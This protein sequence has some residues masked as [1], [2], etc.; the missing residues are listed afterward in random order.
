MPARA[1]QRSSIFVILNLGL[2]LSDAKSDTNSTTTS[3]NLPL[4]MESHRPLPSRRP[5]HVEVSVRPSLANALPQ[6]EE[7]W[8]EVLEATPQ[9]VLLGKHGELDLTKA[10]SDL[11]AATIQ[12]IVVDDNSDD[13]GGN[14]KGIFRRTESFL[15]HAFVL[16]DE[17]A[18]TEE[19]QPAAGGDDEWTAGCDNL[20][21]PH[22]SLH[23]SWE[24]LIFE[25]HIKRQLLDYAQSA[26]LFSDKRVSSHIVQWNRMILFHGKCLFP[27]CRVSDRCRHLLLTI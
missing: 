20:T 5:R 14:A 11:Q 6:L 8:R 18:Y 13:S 4:T 26:L 3:N 24:S 22:S 27:H 9:D 1:L 10:P 2:F 7:K 25:S 19:L 23:G 16:S 21:L 15:V 17:V 12:A